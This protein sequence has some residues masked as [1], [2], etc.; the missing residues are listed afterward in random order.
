MNKLIISLPL[1]AMI[2]SG[3]ASNNVYMLDAEANATKQAMINKFKENQRTPPSEDL[4]WNQPINKKEACLAPVAKDM[5]N[6]KNFK[7]IW[8]GDCK[9][10]YVY[11]LGR[12]IVISD[13]I[14]IEE[15]IKH[16][17]EK[18][19]N[20]GPFIHIDF[21]NQTIAQGIKTKTYNKPDGYSIFKTTISNDGK[22]EKRINI[23][24]IDCDISSTCKVYAKFESDQYP[25]NYLMKAFQDGIT[26]WHKHWSPQ[27]NATNNFITDFWIINDEPI[28]NPPP[29]NIPYRIR[30]KKGQANTLI[31]RNGQAYS[32]KL[33]SISDYWAA[34]DSALDDATKKLVFDSSQCDRL[35][36]AYFYKL[37][38][39][40]FNVPSGIT[41]ED[42]FEIFKYYPDFKSGSEYKHLKNARS[43]DDDD[44]W[45]D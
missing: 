41:K 42:Y 27:G 12:D 4:A 17:H 37:K 24:Y 16:D 5:L 32:L 8:D 10:G 6:Q 20:Y 22:I 15:I 40:N 39:N 30:S 23:N 3:C 44:D 26:H 9:N 38:R 33:I 35:I 29:Q 1:V 45:G 34:T 18:K 43:N 13:E 11:G 28:S 19:V 31:F 25:N 14:H 21:I 2:F 36:K 7:Q